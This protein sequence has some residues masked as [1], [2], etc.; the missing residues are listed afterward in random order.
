M[1]IKIKRVQIG[2]NEDGVPVIAPETT[3]PSKYI[4][5]K[6]TEAEYIY[7]VEDEAEQ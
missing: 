2:V 3:P 6:I 7:T 1:Q 5:C 4:E